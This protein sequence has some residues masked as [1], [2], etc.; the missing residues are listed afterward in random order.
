M[1]GTKMAFTYNYILELLYATPY[2]RNQFKITGIE[3][4][5]CVRKSSVA[6][7]GI[8][9]VLYINLDSQYQTQY[10]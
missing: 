9:T 8:I 4:R 1:K 3:L 5:I 6:E 7:I 2:L 10:H